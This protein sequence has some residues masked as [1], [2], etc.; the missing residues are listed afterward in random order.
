MG[1]QAE[2]GRVAHPTLRLQALLL[3]MGKGRQLRITARQRRH[4]LLSSRLSS[5]TS[6]TLL[7]HSSSSTLVHTH[8]QHIKPLTLPYVLMPLFFRAHA[9]AEPPQRTSQAPSG[10][11]KDKHNKHKEGKIKLSKEE[12]KARKAAKK[13]RKKGSGSDKSGSESDDS[14]DSDSD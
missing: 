5:I 9:E 11:K 7:L 12:K 8:L 10:G 6:S 4:R 3:A 13:H 14:S 2:Q 1:E